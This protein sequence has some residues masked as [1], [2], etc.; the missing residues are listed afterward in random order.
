MKI[1]T[2][3]MT[4]AMDFAHAIA[5]VCFDDIERI[6]I[7]AKRGALTRGLRHNARNQPRVKRVGQ[8]VDA[9]DL[10]ETLADIDRGFDLLKGGFGVAMEVMADGANLFE[11]I[12]GEKR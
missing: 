1:V 6:D 10:R 4:F 2:A 7:G 11:F 9:L 12:V 5:R 3:E 8:N